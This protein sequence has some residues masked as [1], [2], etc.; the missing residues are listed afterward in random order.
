[1][2]TIYILQLMEII[3]KY[4]IFTFN[5]D[6]FVQEIG[7]AMGSPPVPSYANIFMATKIDPQIQNIAK[8]FKESNGDALKLFKR[9]LDD[10]FFIFRGST[11]NLHLFFNEVNQIHPTIKMTINHTTPQ[12]E[13]EE[14]RCSCEPQ[15]SIPFLDVACSIREGQIETDLYRKKTD[16][17]QYLLTSSCHPAQTTANIPFSLGLR[18]VR[19]CSSIENRDKR[20]AELEGLLHRR[21]YSD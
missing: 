13:I 8:N 20:L 9:Y 12:S 17:N 1:M 11:K 10:F 7:A 2:P 3:L 21:G 15:N 18:I 19:I 6:H 16:R 5:Q 4:N 14:D